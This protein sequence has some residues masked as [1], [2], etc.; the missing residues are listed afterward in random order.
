MFLRLSSTGIL[1]YMLVLTTSLSHGSK[2]INYYI[3]F[4]NNM[5]TVRA[6]RVTKSCVSCVRDRGNS[7]CLH[8]TATQISSYCSCQKFQLNIQYTYG[9]VTVSSSSICILCN[10]QH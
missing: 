6:Q 8:S 1:I 7:F 4:T 5:R 2:V 3:T 9:I 10:Q